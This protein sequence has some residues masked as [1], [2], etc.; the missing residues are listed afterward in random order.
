MKKVIK[1]FPYI[2]MIVCGMIIYF[3]FDTGSWFFLII[4]IINTLLGAFNFVKVQV[5]E[6][7]QDKIINKILEKGKTIKEDDLV[8]YEKRIREIITGNVG[9]EETYLQNSWTDMRKEI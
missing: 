6:H 7:T 8:D 5:L 1:F 9:V 4:A 2:Q 3:A